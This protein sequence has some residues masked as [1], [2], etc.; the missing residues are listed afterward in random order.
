MAAYNGFNQFLADMAAAKHDFTSHTYKAM[1]TNTSPDAANVVKADLTEID[2]GNGYVA[3]GAEVP[4]L[5]ASQSEGTLAVSYGD[6]VVITASGGDVGPFRYLP[7][8][9]DTTTGKPLV[10]WFDYGSSIT[11]QDGESLTF[12]CSGVNLF[13]MA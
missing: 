5:S 2:A 1:L 4:I 11:L 8:Y 3:G 6:N 13:T 9:N 10:S 12:K 7:I